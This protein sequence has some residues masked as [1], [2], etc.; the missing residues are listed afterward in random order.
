MFELTKEHNSELRDSLVIAVGQA[1]QAKEEVDRLTRELSE[2]RLRDKEKIDES[3]DMIMQL[4]EGNQRNSGVCFGYGKAGHRIAECPTAANQATEPN[5]GTGPNAGANPNKPKESK[6]NAR[7]FAMTQEEADDANEVVSGTIL[8]QKVPAYALFDC[9]AT[10]SFVSKRLA[11]KLGLKPEL[12][13]EPFRIATPTNKAIETHEIHMDCLIS[14]GNQTF[15]A[16]LIQLVMADF[17]IILGMDWLSRNNAIV[18]CKR[19]RVKL[20]TPNQEEIVY[21][22]K[23][24]ER[25]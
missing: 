1:K 12:L 20:R 5:K 8:I 22:G 25:K 2:A 10:H 24:K 19:K 13:A 3:W 4:S 15:S 14:I 7:V 23:S 17:D 11:K 6:P 16:D 21:H 18:D 9:G